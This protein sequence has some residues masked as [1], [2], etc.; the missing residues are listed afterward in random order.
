[1]TDVAGAVVVHKV[2][3]APP[4]ESFDAWLDPD[5]LS[6]WMCPRPHR[7][8]N[9]E[10]D[11]K[12]GG[13]MRMDVVTGESVV[14]VSGTYLVIDRPRRLR[15]TWWCSDWSPDTA[16]SVVTVTFNPQGADETLMT[17]EHE[18]LPD[19]SFAS[20]DDGWAKVAE[21]LGKVLSAT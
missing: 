19:H 6:I 17:I 1:M 16:P 10:V 11:P 2:L 15:F 20:H 14:T 21:Q 3:P 7:P 8:T 12:V 18:L 9:I 13:V 5:S 4:A